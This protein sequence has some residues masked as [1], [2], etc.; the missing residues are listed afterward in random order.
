MSFCIIYVP[1]DHQLLEKLGTLL[2]QLIRKDRAQASKQF[3][4]QITRG[5]LFFSILWKGVHVNN[6]TIHSFNCINVNGF[7]LL[8]VSGTKR[9]SYL[10]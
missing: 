5:P 9:R 6:S 8:P 2:D 1:I 4:P 3:R 10:S 7:Q